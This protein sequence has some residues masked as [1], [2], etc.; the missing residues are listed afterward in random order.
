MLK[1]AAAVHVVAAVDRI[2]GAH[3]LNDETI[4]DH[5]VHVWLLA[6]EALLDLVVGLLDEPGM[7][8]EVYSG[9]VVVRLLGEGALLRR[10]LDHAPV[11]LALLEHIVLLLVF[12]VGR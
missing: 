1:L 8:V 6:V 3:A 10:C 11:V 5:L 2:V 7:L 12:I 9:Q 4:F